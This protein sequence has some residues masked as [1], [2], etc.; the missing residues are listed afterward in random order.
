[1]A[2][3]WNLYTRFKGQRPGAVYSILSAVY[4]LL[5]TLGLINPMVSIEKKNKVPGSKQSVGGAV[6]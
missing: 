5:S 1:M 6:P 3:P 2:S 4:T